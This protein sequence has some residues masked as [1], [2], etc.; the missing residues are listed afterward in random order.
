MRVCV[1]VMVISSVFTASPQCCVG[2]S[3]KQ[4]KSEKW[5]ED[6]RGVDGLDQ[7]SV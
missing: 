3:V 4:N 2:R 6:A 5:K 7:A 1:V